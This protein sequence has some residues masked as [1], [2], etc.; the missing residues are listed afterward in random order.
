MNRRNFLKTSII[1]S[2]ST[3]FLANLTLAAEPLQSKIS[4]SFEI[5]KNHGHHLNLS[6]EDLVL[7]LQDLQNTEL[8]RIN[9]QGQSGHAH[10]IIL[11]ESD[12]LTILKTGEAEIVSSVDRGHSHQVQILL[13]KVEA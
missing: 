5:S 8:V 4:V 6:L 2:G 12:V 9:I 11:S 1:T 3:T 13:E 7:L 10:N